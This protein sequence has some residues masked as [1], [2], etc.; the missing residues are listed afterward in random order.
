MLSLLSTHQSHVLQKCLVMSYLFGL[1][2]YVDTAS[3]YCVHIEID[4]S[5]RSVANH[6][7][8]VKIIKVR[9]WIL[10]ILRDLIRQ[11]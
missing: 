9:E 8:I 10:V 1:D 11:L 3:M 2:L 6:Y 7:Y 4:L 5:L